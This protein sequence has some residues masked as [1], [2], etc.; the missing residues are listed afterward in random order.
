M[1][2]GCP[3]SKGYDY[4]S[5]YA[6]SPGVRISIWNYCPKCRAPERMRAETILHPL[7]GWEPALT[8]PKCGH[9]EIVSITA[10]KILFPH[11]SVRCLIPICP[12]CSKL[13]VSFIG[14]DMVIDLVNRDKSDSRRVV[15]WMCPETMNEEPPV[16]VLLS[17]TPSSHE[18]VI[19]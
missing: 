15:G 17:G 18:S 4:S 10:E 9:V 2:E 6:G 13:M 12:C 11:Q 3:P 14:T 19:R 7:E 5:A 1:C 8:C 16:W